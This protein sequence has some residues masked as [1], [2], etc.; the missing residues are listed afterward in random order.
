M[1]DLESVRK[2]ALFGGTFDPV[3]EGHMEVAARA[4]EILSLDS[5]IFLPCRQ[6]PHKS[7]AAG[8][9]EQQRFEMLK[10]ATQCFS[11]AQISDWEFQQPVPSYSWRTAEAYSEK[12]PNAQLYWLMGQDQWKVLSSW[13]RADYFA[14][15]VQFIVHDRDGVADEGSEGAHFISGDHPASS[16]QI[17]DSIHAGEKI[18]KGWLSQDVISY[19]EKEGLYRE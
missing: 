6:S 15:L 1:A 2:I 7:S 8:A 9:S 3:H 17:R 18:E 10:R 19:L 11:W 13:S 4:V 12:Y 14:S 16:S 5:V